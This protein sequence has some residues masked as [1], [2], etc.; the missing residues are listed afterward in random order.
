MN[1]PRLESLRPKY[2]IS[3][4]PL[5][6]LKSKRALAKLLKWDGTGNTLDAFAR[7]TDNYQRFDICSEGKAPRAVQEPKA[8]LH[9]IHR[10]IA[11]LLL[12][13]EL[14]DY[15][16]SGRRGRSFVTNGL[17][18]V[19]AMPAFKLDIRKFYPSTKWSH[20]YNCFANDFECAPDVAAVL[21]S[22]ATVEA[23]GERHLPTGSALS[24]ILAYFTFRRLFDEID[25][26]ARRRQ[27]V[28]TLYVD[29]MVQSLPDA[30]P[31]DIRRVGRMI[32]RYGLCWHKQKFFG[33]RA[34]KHVTGTVVKRNHLGASN[35]HHHRF[36]LALDE[37]LAY[38]S[39]PQRALSARRAIGLLQ[40]IAQ[41]DPKHARTAA[42]VSESLRRIMR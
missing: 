10:R 3:R 40:M 25:A 15:L 9:A 19:N 13:I 22:L 4:S 33:V 30:S 38:P 20:V 28:F 29:D 36:R 23:G 24:Q 27:G 32:S 39:L 1:V 16:H 17:A 6:R 8:T 21:A 18:H 7:Q 35:R 34:A 26:F 12:R 42:L 41:V 11:K 14:P 37:V 31:V 2:P 5:F